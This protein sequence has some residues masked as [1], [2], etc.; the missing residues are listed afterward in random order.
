MK[1][2]KRCILGFLLI[3]LT[4]QFLLSTVVSAPAPKQPIYTDSVAVLMYHHVHETDRSSG[5]IKTSLFRAQLSYLKQRGYHFI[6]L[7]EFR[8]YIN[9]GKV[10]PNAVLVTFDDG[11]E[12]FYWN[13]FP[14]LQE[15]HVP[16]VNFYVTRRMFYSGGLHVPPMKRDQI[17]NMLNTVPRIDIQFHTHNMH[18]KVNGRAVLAYRLPLPHG[19]MES[20]GMYRKR[21][22]DDTLICRKQLKS[23]QVRPVDSFAYPYGKYSK[24]AKSAIYEAGIRYAF[25][26][27]PG[28]MT[29]HANRMTIPRINA[30]NPSITPQ[31]LH[32]YIVRLAKSNSA[33]K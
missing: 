30:G 23:L 29:R 21:V 11:Y 28:I 8:Q 16:A 25:T 1:R 3:M 13:A 5:T 20:R 33:V 2:I 15:L 10:P 26:I 18:K 4:T 9:G 19:R 22:L 27:R 12:S 17:K 32:D 14:I 31:K 6:S 7:E 24:D